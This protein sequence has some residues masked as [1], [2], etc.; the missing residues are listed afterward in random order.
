[1]DEPWEHA[2]WKKP[3]SEGHLN[4][5]ECTIL[6][7]SR[8]GTSTQ[9]LPGARGREQGV[10]ANGYVVGFGDDEYA[11]ELDSS[12]GAALREHNKMQGKFKIM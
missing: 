1:M 2:K 10:N 12:A 6:L 5:I 11:L 4:I 8:M 9:W 3:A 7:T